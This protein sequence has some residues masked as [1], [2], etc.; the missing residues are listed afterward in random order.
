MTPLERK[1]AT[2]DSCRNDYRDY[3]SRVVGD[4]EAAD[5][6]DNF[7]EVSRLVKVLVNKRSS[8]IMPSKDHSGNLITSSE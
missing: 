3:I 1:S 4:M 7:R 5:R 8:S 2:R 6:S